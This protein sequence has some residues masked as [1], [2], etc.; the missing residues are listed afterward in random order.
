MCQ[1]LVCSVQLK[2][3]VSILVTWTW[4][5]DMRIVDMD[6]DLRIVHSDLDLGHEDRG[7]GLRLE[8]C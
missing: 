5:W 1:L 2:R 3:C 4:T 6:S 8:N 7:H